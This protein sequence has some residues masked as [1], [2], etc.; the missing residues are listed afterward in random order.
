MK[1]VIM[2]S[3]AVSQAVLAKLKENFENNGHTFVQYEKTSD[4]PTLIQQAK[5]AD[6]MMIANMPM[7]SQVISACENLKFISVAFTGVDHIDL[8]AAKAKGIAVSNASGYSDQSVAEMVL[9]MA[10]ALGRNIVTVE[11]RCRNGETKDGLVGWELKGK[12]VGIIGLGRIGLRTAQLFKAFGC[13][14]LTSYPSE[15]GKEIA[16]LVDMDVL[17][18][19]SD[20]VTLHCPLKD[21]TRSLIN[22][23]QLA[24]MKK[25]AILINAA[26]GPVVVA[27]DLANA[28]NNEVIAGA[29]V[30]VFD[31]EP[32]LDMSEPLLNCKNCLVTPHV[33]FAT[34][35]SMVLRA[36]IVFDNLS[37]WM[38]GCQ[39]N[40]IL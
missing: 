4:I 16:A 34:K 8:E 40:I 21:S 38:D 22:A 39:K 17:L 3:L 24:K 23:K 18:A 20:I 29:G 12:T 14:I 26:R 36:Q 31:K 32:P 28:L 6:V 2:E 25:T 30:D 10:L 13:D 15:R 1:V 27:Q 11:Q 5:D 9:G 7:P 35:E 19:K 37:A 33:A